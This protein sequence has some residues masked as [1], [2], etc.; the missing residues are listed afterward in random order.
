MAGRVDM[1]CPHCQQD[2]V[3]QNGQSL[4]GRQRWL[5]W[6]YRRTLGKSDR[7]RHPETTQQQA[8]KLYWEGAVFAALNGCWASARSP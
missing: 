1:K 4:P 7:W 2:S 3:V 6:D 5:C 8:R